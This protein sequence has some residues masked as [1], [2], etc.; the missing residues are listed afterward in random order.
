MFCYYFLV[1]L[2]LQ[3]THK[4]KSQAADQEAEQPRTDNI[5]HSKGEAVFG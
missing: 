2:S 4:K 1:I 3:E 5:S